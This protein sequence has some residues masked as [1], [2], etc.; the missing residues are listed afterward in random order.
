MTSPHP[1][2]GSSSPSDGPSAHRL[3]ITATLTEAI[4]EPQVEVALA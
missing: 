3:Y 2:I 1:G 4:A